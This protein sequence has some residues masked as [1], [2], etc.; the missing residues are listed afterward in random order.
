M[1]SPF[2]DM[3]DRLRALRQTNPEASNRSFSK[4]QRERLKELFLPLFEKGEFLS[5]DQQVAFVKAYHPDILK[6]NSAVVV[7]AKYRDMKK[8]FLDKGRV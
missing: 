7:K 8:R 4:D 3:A 2:S 6:S 5:G 1:P